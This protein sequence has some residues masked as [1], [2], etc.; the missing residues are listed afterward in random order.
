MLGD[1]PQVDIQGVGT[2]GQGQDV[3]TAAHAGKAVFRGAAVVHL[4]DQLVAIEG[5]QVKT[6]EVGREDPQQLF[7]LPGFQAV[8]QPQRLV[9]RCGIE[10]VQFEGAE[11]VA[12]AFG[13][14]VAKLQ[15]G[16]F[17]EQN[18]PS[19]AVFGRNREQT[20]QG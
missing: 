19:T 14:Y 11:L 17:V 10:L 9:W 4:F 18:C 1:Q 6:G 5:V 20:E 8:M 3:I 2:V 16:L 7:V 13:T 12:V 15:V